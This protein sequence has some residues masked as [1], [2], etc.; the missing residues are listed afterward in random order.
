MFT[1]LFSGERIRLTALRPEDAAIMARWYE[2]GDFS[3]QWESGVAR[4]RTEASL[5]KR[6]ADMDETKTDYAFAIRLMYSD[7]MIGYVDVSDIQWNNGAAWI[8]IGIGDPVNRGKGF[9]YEA[10]TLLLKFAFHELNLHRVQLTVFSYNERAIKLYERL[11]F[12]REGMFR[13]FLARD[14]RRYD[15][16]L[17]GMLKRE[18]EAGVPQD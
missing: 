14:G 10:M 15:M 7:E 18:W 1:P 2:D 9:G 12:T 4:P 11:G 5:R 17:Y 16:I 8:A 3:R 6:F 13:E